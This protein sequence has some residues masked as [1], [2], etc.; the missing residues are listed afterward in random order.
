MFLQYADFWRGGEDVCERKH[1][2]GL[3]DLSTKIAVSSDSPM[4]EVNKAAS[5]PSTYSSVPKSDQ[6][7]EEEEVSA[8]N[9]RVANS[10]TSFLEFE[11]RPRGSSQTV[12]AP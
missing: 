4:S 12:L 7:K 6:E 9:E 10:P 5:D 1:M 11:A 2:P 8:V 3:S